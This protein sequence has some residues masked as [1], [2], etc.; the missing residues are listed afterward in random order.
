MKKILTL[1]IIT[2]IITSCSSNKSM[3]TNMYGHWLS[4]DFYNHI[5]STKN[6]QEFNGIKLEFVI[7]ETDTNYTMI[8]FNGK[9]KSGPLE[10]LENK[11]LVIKNYFG[12]YK[13]ADILLED[14][15]LVFINNETND[16]ISFIKIKNEE[17]KA[18]ELESYS[19]FSL[20][21]INKN[22]IS[23]K[24]LLNSDTVEFTTSGNII[25][26]DKTVNYS[27]CLNK[28][29]RTSNNFNTIFLSN[30]V[31]EGFYHE[32]LFRNDS[33]IIFSVDEASV[34]RGNNAVTT[35][36]KYKMKKIN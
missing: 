10:L 8:D 19:S 32:Y 34:N 6:L 21:F 27:F 31:Y 13:N 16:K 35:G 23:G 5:N 12:N 17:F 15:K 14:E 7:P 36:V 26:L 18:S 11:Q 9:I 3:N 30:S 28:S 24:Y 25:N 22:Y 2:L 20:P 1:A 33:L 29:C 4:E